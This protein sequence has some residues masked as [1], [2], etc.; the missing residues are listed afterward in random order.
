MELPPNLHDNLTWMGFTIF[1]SYTVDKQRA[2][3]S[4]KQ[5]SSIFL[6]FYG[7]S[8]SDEVP[9]APYIAFPLSRDVFDESSRRLLVFYIPRARFQLNCSSHIRASFGSDNQV[10]KVETCGIRIVY[11]QDVEQFVQ[12]LVQCMLE[13]PVAYRPS[14]Y[15]NLLH[16]LALLQD[17]N[18][19]RGFCSSF[20]SERSKLTK[21]DFITIPE[22]IIYQIF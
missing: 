20:L 3:W 22:R 11:E 13:I 4:Y 18:H 2:G 7:F 6:H 15:Q 14:L 12:T 1:A 17:C 5:N 8:A 10:V 19:E 9:L 21:K 16:Q